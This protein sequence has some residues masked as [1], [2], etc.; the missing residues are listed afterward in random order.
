MCKTTGFCSVGHIYA[1]ENKLIAINTLGKYHVLQKVLYVLMSSVELNNLH[2]IRYPHICTMK[3]TR[4][5]C[6]YVVLKCN[7][8]MSS[9]NNIQKYSP[10]INSPLVL[11]VDKSQKFENSAGRVIIS[12]DTC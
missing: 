4:V 5:I 1:F 2:V 11:V 9:L 12:V 6:V 7:F 10:D 8:I 3:Q